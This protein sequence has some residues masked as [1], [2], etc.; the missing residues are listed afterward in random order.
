MGKAS[1]WFRGLLGLKKP[2][3]PSTTTPPK[4]P[5]EK[6][7]WSFVKSYRE[8][9]NN[10]HNH[11]ATVE[12]ADPNR[13]ALAVAAAT[14]AMAEAAIAA[15]HAATTV[16]KITKSSRSVTGDTSREEWAAL[17]IQAAFRGSLARKA[18]RA[19]KGLVKL[20]ALVRGHIER[21][22]TAEWLQKMQALIRAQARVRAGRAQF[23][24][25]PYKFANSSTGPLHGPATPEKLESPIRSKSMKYDQSPSLLKRNSSNEQLWNHRRSW[26]GTCSMDDET[27]I[28]I[29][30]IDSGKPH[31]TSK[32]RNLFHSASQVLIPDHYYSQILTPTKDSTSYTQSP[33]SC[34]VHENSPQILSTSSKDDGSNK[35]SPFTPT[36]SDGSRSY[37]SAYSD[38]PSYMAYTESSKA[39]VRSLS[40][41]KQRP[42]YERCSSS[43]R[44]LLSR[45]GES[46]LAPQRVSALQANFATKAYPGSGYLD[47][48]GLP[49]GCRY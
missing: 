29:L 30:E 42:Q 13:H 39:K 19:L 45:F 31:I 33:S 21:K 28:K 34:E 23:L 38:Y 6:R 46:K 35:R 44:N 18:L 27:S 16:T 32:R 8:K 15:A 7:R 22:R 36:K 14:A 41:P 12:S 37:L 10:Q 11:D 3:S 1:K 48:L 5:K 40:A 47:K 24:Q 20:Q 9:D 25:S 4:P 26:L 49:V 17:K 2:D 43:N